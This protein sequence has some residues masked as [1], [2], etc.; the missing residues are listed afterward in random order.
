LSSM[1]RLLFLSVLF[2]ISCSNNKMVHE[3]TV[4]KDSMVQIIVDMHLADAMLISP[5][6]QQKPFKINS[7]K[8]YSAILEKHKISKKSFEENLNY[9][10]SDTA[11][12][13]IIYK[14]VIKRLTILQ[15]DLMNNDSLA[16][17][18]K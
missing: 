10:S 4:S 2:V 12:F 18:R 8:F 7:E 13:K 1:F 5:L 14:D 17:I 9:F 15:G 6:V 16:K 11:Q 3:N